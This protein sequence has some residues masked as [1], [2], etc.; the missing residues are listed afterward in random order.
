MV[1]FD[2]VCSSNYPGGACDASSQASGG[3]ESFQTCEVNFTQPVML[4]VNVFDVE[5]HATCKYDALTVDGVKHCGP[6][7]SPDGDCTGHSLSRKE[8]APLPRDRAKQHI[9]LTG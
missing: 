6:A 3:Y 1:H 4:T 2:C 7:N 8:A 5:T 9:S